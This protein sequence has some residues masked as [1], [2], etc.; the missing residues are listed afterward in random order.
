MG[1]KRGAATKTP[2]GTPVVTTPAVDNLNVRPFDW[3]DADRAYHN[4]VEN[5]RRVGTEPMA[6]DE[7][8]SL[9]AEWSAKLAAG[10]KMRPAEH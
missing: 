8:R 9:M 1:R 2:A 5:C 4:Y 3:A 7:A 6:W 10:R